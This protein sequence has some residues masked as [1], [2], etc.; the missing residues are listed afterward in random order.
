MLRDSM[1]RMTPL[2]HLRCSLPM[3]RDRHYRF[4]VLGLDP[5]AR[6]FRRRIEL[7][8]HAITC[9]D[10]RCHQS[11]ANVS[12]MVA[13]DKA[14]EPGFLGRPVFPRW[15]Q[16]WSAR[17]SHRS[18]KDKRMDALAVEHLDI[19]HLAR[20]LF[21][22]DRAERGSGESRYQKQTGE[23]FGVHKTWLNE[24]GR[25]SLFDSRSPAIY[26]PS[27]NKGVAGQTPGNFQKKILSAAEPRQTKQSKPT[28]KENICCGLSSLCC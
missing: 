7:I 23:E 26:S 16:D 12:A 6:P 8:A 17:C 2:P 9:E 27:P 22:Y 18:A 3:M 15:D 11:G 24:Q 20:I 21:H 4:V 13:Q 19:R 10:F 1:R 25:S 14:V 5:I 28:Q